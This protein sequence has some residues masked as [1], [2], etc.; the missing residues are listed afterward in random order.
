ML[1][2]DALA[3]DVYWIRTIQHYGRDRR[4]ARTDDRFELLQPLLDLTTTLDPHFNIAYRFGAV[5]LAEPPPS[6]PG[7]PDQAIALLQKGLRDNPDRWQYAF[8][9]GFIYYWHG[10]RSRLAGFH[11]RRR[12]WF[13]RAARDAAG[14][15]LAAVAGGDDAGA[16]RRPAGRARLL[17]VSWRRRKRRGC[18]SRGAGSTRLPGARRDR[19]TST[20]SGRV[21]GRAL[22][23]RP[24]ASW[25]DLNPGA[26]RNAV[27]VDPAGVPYEYDAARPARRPLIE[28][29]ARSAAAGA[30]RQVTRVRARSLVASSGLMIGSFLNVCISRL[31]A[32][33]SVVFPGSR[34]P[35]CRTPIRW[36]DNLPVVSYVLLGG[37]C[38]ACR[39]SIRAR[40]PIVERVT[41]A[42]F[43][44]QALFWGDDPLMLAA[45]LVLTG[46]LVA[47]FGTDLETQRLPN[48][49]TI[50]GAIAGLLFSIW[51]PPGVSSSVIGLALGAVILLGIRWL[52]RR[53]AGTEG[54]GWAT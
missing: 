39:A 50:P 5:F 22:H 32:G 34:C 29:S 37:R 25:A 16:G 19:S 43:V 11:E 12:D 4:S 54:W 15:G 24:P 40:Y 9:I 46:L 38:R 21:H 6:G 13:E 53:V 45:R 35:S 30:G 14:A 7:R 23:Q 51:L 2:F 42:A 48:V 1:S 49:L 20:P 26:P 27:P 41:A 8:D 3:A 10:A 31:P 44:T 36:H 18:A 17:S 28:L 33:E 47:L 52:W